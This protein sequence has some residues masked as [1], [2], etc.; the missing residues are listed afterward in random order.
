MKLLY[1]GSNT[2]IDVIELL[3]RIKKVSVEQI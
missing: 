3:S 1:H 2:D